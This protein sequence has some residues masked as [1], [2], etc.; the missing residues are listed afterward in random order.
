[1]KSL[2]PRPSGAC[3]LQSNSRPCRRLEIFSNLHCKLIK[4][5][6]D[7]LMLFYCHFVAGCEKS[8]CPPEGFQGEDCK[9]WC[10]GNPVRQCNNQANYINV[11]EEIPNVGEIIL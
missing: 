3:H 5:L 6:I 9:C 7:N 4:Y 2:A 8:A 11:E 1:M 10:K